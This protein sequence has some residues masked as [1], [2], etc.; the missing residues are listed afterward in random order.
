[1]PTALVCSDEFA[2]LARAESRA[3]GMGGQ[4]LVVVPH[5]VADNRPDEIARK[6][7][8]ITD[9]V[10]AILT[11][12]AAELAERY[13]DRFLKLADRRLER[14]GVCTEQVCILD[15]DRGVPDAPGHADLDRR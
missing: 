7:A 13:R 2:P 11:A 3:R 4:P 6:A 1:V 9:E 8:G 5:P 12:P 10:V 15:V 14:S